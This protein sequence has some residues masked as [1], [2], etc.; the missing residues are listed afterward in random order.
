M[1]LVIVL[2]AAVAIFAGA[3]L[4]R[5]SGTG[6]GLVVAPTLTL[7]IGP[8]LGV[9]LSN[10]TTIVSGLLIMFA[11]LHEV[12]W[13]RYA[14]I[15]PAAAIGAIPAAFMVRD[16]SAAW[17]NIFIGSVVLFAL[18]ITFGLPTLPRMKSRTLTAAAGMVGGFLNTSSGVAAPAMVIYSKLS[19]WGQ[20]SFAATMQP[21]FM[22]LG[23]LSVGSKLAAGSFDYSALPPWWFFVMVVAMV[24]VGMQA[25]G[26]A[27]RKISML[28]A[29]RVA[30]TLA[31][32]GALVAVIRGIVMLAAG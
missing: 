16:L 10:A 20:R 13:K 18:A 29:R 14:I 21:T 8:H 24:I 28:L 32:L 7:L 12:D 19:G 3:V 31:G 5:V 30:I 11:V 9:F 17:L 25:G 6:V 27:A 22:T 15:A 26:F 1:S 23:V 2:I 4:Q